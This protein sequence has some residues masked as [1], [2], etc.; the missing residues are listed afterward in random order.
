MRVTLQLEE[1]A[2]PL[3][4]RGLPPRTYPHRLKKAIKLLRRE[5]GFKARV[6]RDSTPW[7][8]LEAE[9]HL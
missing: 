3:C 8:L 4:R 2:D 9:D 7:E 6:V 1:E 5:L